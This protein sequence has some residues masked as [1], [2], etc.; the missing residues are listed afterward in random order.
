MASTAIISITVISAFLLS[1]FL[2]Y[3]FINTVTN[4]VDISNLDHEE[5]DF[6]SIFNNTNKSIF[7][8]GSSQ[9]GRLNQTYI[10]EGIN[11]MTHK[12]EIGL[13]LALRNNG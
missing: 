3:L 9:I 1:I 12:Y 2:L 11:P 4:T 10:Q 5:N 7:L 13:P 6:Y 8:I